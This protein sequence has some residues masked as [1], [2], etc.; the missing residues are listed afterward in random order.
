MM[1][2]DTA[3]QPL[4]N[5]H[6]RGQSLGRGAG[7]QPNAAPVM[8]HRQMLKV[9]LDR[10]DRDEAAHQFAGRHALAKLAARQFSEDGFWCNVAHNQS[11]VFKRV[12][13]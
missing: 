9:L 11:L 4:G 12:A 13:I 7:H 8:L 1:L 10:R 3:H 2:A 5:E 6:A